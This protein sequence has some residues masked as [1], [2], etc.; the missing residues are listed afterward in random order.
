MQVVKQSAEEESSIQQV[1]RLA[2]VER[3]KAKEGEVSSLKIH[4]KA[5][6]TQ[7][8]ANGESEQVLAL[9]QTFTIKMLLLLDFYLAFI[10]LS[11]K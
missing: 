10:R 6:I 9:I 2:K 11:I 5:K 1:P 4:I 8:L 3:A 7:K